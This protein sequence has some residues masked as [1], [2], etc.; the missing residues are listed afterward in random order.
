M[1][2]VAGRIEHVVVLMLE[3]RSFDSMLGKLYPKGPGF[4]GLSGDETNPQT[5]VNE[6]RV[7][8]SAA[9]DA[10]RKTDAYW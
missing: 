2:D 4:D 3:N 7:W 9:V 10:A 5:G 8:G 6:V 1:G